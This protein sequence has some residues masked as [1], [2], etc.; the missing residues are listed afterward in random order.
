MQY[1]RVDD[2]ASSAGSVYIW[3]LKS[4][5]LDPAQSLFGTATNGISVARI[6]GLINAVSF[7]PNWIPFYGFL[8]GKTVKAGNYRDRCTNLEFN[9]F[10]HYINVFSSTNRVGFLGRIEHTGDSCVSFEYVY[11][12]TLCTA[13]NFG[14]FKDTNTY[15]LSSTNNFN[16][17]PVVE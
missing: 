10:P 2:T 6:G 5:T 12:T 9:I 13:D 16:S 7:D 4:Y 17:V 15:T 8:A 11:T 14:D 3:Q 1:N